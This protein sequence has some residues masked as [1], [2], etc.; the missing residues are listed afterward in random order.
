MNICHKKGS[1]FGSDIL[2]R[3]T[4]ISG[5]I[6]VWIYRFSEKSK[7]IHPDNDPNKQNDWL[8]GG[9]AKFKGNR[10][11]LDITNAR[12]DSV[13][14]GWRFNP[15]KDKVQVTPYFHEADGTRHHGDWDDQI[16]VFDMNYGE[17][18]IFAVAR[19]QKTNKVR[20]LTQIAKNWQ[21]YTPLTNAHVIDTDKIDC[22][23]VGRF[24]SSYAGGDFA[25]P[26]PI[27]FERQLLSVKQVRNS[28]YSSILSILTDEY[29]NFH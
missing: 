6:W 29:A 17:I 16:P 7:Y 24:I 18:E 10:S 4:P 5:D 25:P 1:F 19:N 28:P 12:Q 26:S 11:L 13:M 8:K 20:I 21:Q 3:L 27:S 15:S 9:G 2:T 22:K 23:G 14:N